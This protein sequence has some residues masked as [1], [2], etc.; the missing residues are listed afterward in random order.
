MNAKETP[1]DLIAQERRLR[2]LEFLKEEGYARVT[3]L[4]RMFEVTEPTIRQDLDKLEQDGFILRE[5]GGAVLRSVSQQVRSLSLQHTENMDKKI[6]IAKKAAEFVENGNSIILDSGSTTTELAKQLHGKRDIK[7]ITNAL[8]IALIIGAEQAQD[9]LVTG[10]EF[11]PPTLSLT[12]E[13]AA[14]FFKGVF[15]D[16]LF[17]ATGGISPSYELTYPGFADI[18]VKESMINAAAE[19]FLLA[20]SSK[21]AKQAFASLNALDKVHYLITDS[22][23][24]RSFLSAIE[25][26]GIKVILA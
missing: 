6:I 19:V 20:D 21:M 7:V 25:A 22:R 14:T 13:K 4:S 24:D 9:I 17:L 1:K 3:K 8:N 23:A 5:H 10:G 12:G 11:K 26:R 16:K 18:P 15:V 2:I